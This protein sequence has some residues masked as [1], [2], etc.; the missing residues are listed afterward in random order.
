MCAQNNLS[1]HC[2]CHDTDEISH[3]FLSYMRVNFHREVSLS[4]FVRLTTLNITNTMTAHRPTTVSATWVMICAK[5][6][7]FPS[8]FPAV[9]VE[10]NTGNGSLSRMVQP[11][12]H[13][14]DGTSIS[15]SNQLPLMKNFFFWCGQKVTK[16]KG[17]L[18]EKKLW[19]ISL[20]DLWT[21]SVL[22]VAVLGL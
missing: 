14:F 15:V 22:F 17:K 11:G 13:S 19:N 18:L 5:N 21:R 20:S 1:K 7:I 9:N 16:S 8:S 12:K 3:T 6:T 10:K 4:S 2:L